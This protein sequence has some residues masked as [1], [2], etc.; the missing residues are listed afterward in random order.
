MTR[1]ASAARLS[2]NSGTI[3]ATRVCRSSLPS[4]EAFRERGDA[5]DGVGRDLLRAAGF[6]HAVGFHQGDLAILHDGDSETDEIRRCG[7]VVEHGAEF[8]ELLVFLGQLRVRGR[9]RCERQSGGSE[10]SGKLQTVS[11]RV[12]QTIAGFMNPLNRQCANP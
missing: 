4:F 10:E 5:E 1:A 12:R 2:L 3:V 7:G 9:R 6:A 8:L 11:P